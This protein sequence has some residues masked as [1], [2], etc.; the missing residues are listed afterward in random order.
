ME[1]YASGGARFA[2]AAT[3][4]IST[5]K[6]V[7]GNITSS[8]GSLATFGC[9]V[10]VIETSGK[11]LKAINDSS[12]AAAGGWSSSFG[13]SIIL[14]YTSTWYEYMNHFF[15]SEYEVRVQQYLFTKY[16]LEDAGGWKIVDKIF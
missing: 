4:I 10:S 7:R 3:Q 15:V 6:V 12:G 14:F 13:W 1:L 11:G 16:I 8:S 9:E 5:T 2:C